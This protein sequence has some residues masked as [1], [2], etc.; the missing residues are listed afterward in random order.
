MYY[1]VPLPWVHQPGTPPRCYRCHDRARPRRRLCGPV[2]LGFPI[3]GCSSES[4]RESR[5]KSRQGTRISADRPDPELARSRRLDRSR[6][7]PTSGFQAL[8]AIRVL[9][10]GA[11][12]PLLVS[13]KEPRGSWGSS[14]SLSWS[15][16]APRGA[17]RLLRHPGNL[18]KTSEK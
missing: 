5:R 18:L 10:W 4:R 3:M 11:S 17:S 6:G 9:L 13:W 2:G 7:Y 15:P 12:R 16:G 14:R 1:R 8:R